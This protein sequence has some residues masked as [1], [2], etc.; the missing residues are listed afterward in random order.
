MKYITSIVL[1]L[2]LLP[3]CTCSGKQPQRKN[4]QDPESELYNF[5]QANS[6]TVSSSS[7]SVSASIP[8]T[9]NL[10]AAYYF[11]NN[12]DDSSV[13][14]RDLLDAGLQN[15]TF[16]SGQLGGAADLTSTSDYAT[17]NTF[18]D[19]NIT[20]LTFCFWIKATAING[21]IFHW[22]C[23]SG[24]YECL[25]KTQSVGGDRIQF[26]I[27][28][29]QAQSET[30]TFY[31]DSW[32]HIAMVWENNSRSLFVDGEYAGGYTNTIT[33]P[34]FTSAFSI[35]DGWSISANGDFLIDDMFIYNTALNQNQ[36][37]NLMSRAD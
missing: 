36:I 20:A 9:N 10:I 23:T 17:N 34:A 35:G 4:P 19:T 18:P 28:N 31:I 13:H 22:W 15:I 27:D 3:F 29:D 7:S 12:L 26:N 11:D 2:S 37:S 14:N 33:P 24:S 5:S 1:F 32:Y 16:T 21:Y 8:L 30:G 6:S 25:A